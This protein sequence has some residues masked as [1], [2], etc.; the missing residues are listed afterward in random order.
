MLRALLLAALAQ[1]RSVPTE[2]MNS[3]ETVDDIIGW[4]VVAPAPKADT[5]EEMNRWP[6]LTSRVVLRSVERSDHEA[7]HRAMNDASSS[8]RLPNRGMSVPAAGFEQSLDG[9][10]LLMVAA[11]RTDSLRPSTL[12]ALN[13]FDPLNQRASLSRIGLRLGLGDEIGPAARM[14]ATGMFLSHAFAVMPLHKITANIPAYN[15]S[16]FAEGEGVFFEVEGVHRE[17]DLIGGSRFDV[18]SI[19]IFR[20]RWTEVES[21]LVQAVLAMSA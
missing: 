18:T 3:L 5:V 15:Y 20:D 8:W 19:A 17:H 1:T 10:A 12:F 21:W 14:E 16:Q 6:L 4:A 9:A 13:D 7:I 2:L 11:S